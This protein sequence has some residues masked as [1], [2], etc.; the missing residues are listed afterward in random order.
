MSYA[1]GD[2]NLDRFM[3]QSRRMIQKTHG[4]N[5][6]SLAA[7]ARFAEQMGLSR[8]EMDAAGAQ[9]GLTNAEIRQVVDEAGLGS[10][11]GGGSG[12]LTWAL[13]LGTCA[14]L[15]GVGGGLG[16]Y[17][18]TQQQ[19]QDNNSQIAENNEPKNEGNKN[20]VPT[21]NIEKKKDQPNN[22]GGNPDREKDK[23]PA[24][25]PADNKYVI[26]PVLLEVVANLQGVL[27]TEQVTLEYLK[28]K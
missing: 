1:A 25:N 10:E 3:D 8:E 14:I 13:I 17:L 28:Y 19:Q 7:M 11:G 16:Y 4:V 6:Q 9:L 21:P 2:A 5:D 27:F 23:I 26:D 20:K 15:L 24:P 18:W 22:T 12:V